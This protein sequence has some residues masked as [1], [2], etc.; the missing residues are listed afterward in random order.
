MWG[1]GMRR[2]GGIAGCSGRVLQSGLLGGLFGGDGGTRGRF[3]A[4]FD[5]GLYRVV[6]VVDGRP[7]KDENDAAAR[8]FVFGLF[9]CEDSR[10]R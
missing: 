6:D 4:T 9:V 2:G 3:L 7:A 10:M 1:C 5:V 8:K